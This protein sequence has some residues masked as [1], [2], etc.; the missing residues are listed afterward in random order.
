MECG[1]SAA[2]R[3]KAAAAAHER[4]NMFTIPPL[5][6]LA[7]LSLMINESL[8]HKLLTWGVLVYSLADTI[9]VVAVPH[10]MPSG[11]RFI[12]VVLHHLVVIYLALHPIFHPENLYL[13]AYY[14]IV[15]VNTVCLNIRRAFRW[16]WS[17]VAFFATWIVLR[18]VWYPYLVYHLHTIMLSQQRPP[19]SHAWNQVVGTSAALTALNYFW[20][21]E[22]ATDKLGSKN[23]SKPS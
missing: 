11:S 16:Q 17:T 4:F 10:C 6:I 2:E 22:I 18:L 12:T 3:G 1:Q 21:A 19:G 13:T 5:A 7:V 20:T 8:L 23:K 15:E 9:Y 14:A